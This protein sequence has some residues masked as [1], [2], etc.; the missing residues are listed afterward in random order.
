MAWPTTSNPRTNFVTVRFTDDEADDL[1]MLGS[2]RSE[3]IRDAVA[4]VVAIEKRKLAKKKL[5]A[6]EEIPA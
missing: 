3:A 1:D 2:S 5:V 6:G 4:R